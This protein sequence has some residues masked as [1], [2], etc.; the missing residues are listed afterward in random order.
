MIILLNTGCAN[1]GKSARP[2]CTNTDYISCWWSKEVDELPIT[3][4]HP[5]IFLLSKHF[6]STQLDLSSVWIGW[7]FEYVV[8]QINASL[9]ILKC[10]FPVFLS[11]SRLSKRITYSLY[12]IFCYTASTQ[13][14]FLLWDQKSSGITYTPLDTTI[15][16]NSTILLL[17]YKAAVSSCLQL[18]EK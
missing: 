12:F 4:L 17:L 9:Y 15:L 14:Y 1:R 6:S 5:E 8:H 3:I 18:N 11:S 10:I 7:H 16:S 2:N 13:L